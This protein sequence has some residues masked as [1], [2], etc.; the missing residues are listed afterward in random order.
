MYKSR[1]MYKKYGPYRGRKPP[2]PSHPP[3]MSQRLVDLQN[4]ESRGNDEAAKSYDELAERTEG[5]SSSR[6]SVGR[7]LGIGVQSNT[8]SSGLI[9]LQRER[10]KRK[11]SSLPD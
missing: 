10:F 4:N 5:A 7:Q 1:I 2:P 3:A 6:F 8:T 9:A 11:W